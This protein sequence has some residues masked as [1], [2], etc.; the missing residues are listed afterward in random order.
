[1]FDLNSKTTQLYT[2]RFTK[3]E[4]EK[5]DIPIPE[6]G[7]D[8]NL[9]KI[10]K[11]RYKIIIEEK[12]ED[13]QTLLEQSIKENKVLVRNANKLKSKFLLYAKDHTHLYDFI[14]SIEFENSIVSI[15]K[16]NSQ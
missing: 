5:L 15:P 2:K 3:A 12:R 8:M 9:Q 14:N 7:Y 13:F 4:W 10:L 16:K 6:L 11:S 1:M